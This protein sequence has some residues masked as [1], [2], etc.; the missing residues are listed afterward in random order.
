MCAYVFQ[1][2]EKLSELKIRHSI[3]NFQ[4]L[5]FEK[6]DLYK[7]FTV[8]VLMGSIHEN[9]LFFRCQREILIEE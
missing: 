1:L 6:R 9:F 4:F 5:K 8:S 3:S 2:L 7:I